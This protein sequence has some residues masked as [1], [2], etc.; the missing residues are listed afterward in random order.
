MTGGDALEY[1]LFVPVI[2]HVPGADGSLRP[3]AEVTPYEQML[4]VEEEVGELREELLL[5]VARGGSD[6]SDTARELADCVMACC[7]LAAVLGVDL[8]GAMADCALRQEE[9]GR[10]E[11]GRL[12]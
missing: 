2:D 9:R 8:Q 5:G 6:W 7:T 1:A 4:A 10:Y 11:P 12:R 3:R